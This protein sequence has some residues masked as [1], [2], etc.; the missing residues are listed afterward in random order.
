MGGDGMAVDTAGNVYVAGSGGIFVFDSGGGPLGTIT[1][2][3]VPANCT[4]GG[5]DGKT[6]YITA[7]AGL[8]SIRLNVPGLP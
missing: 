6:L 1:V 4:F 5:A 7:R 3:E 2:P 8:Y